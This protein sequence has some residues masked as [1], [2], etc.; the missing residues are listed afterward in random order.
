FIM[1]QTLSAIGLMVLIVAGPARAQDGPRAIIAKA[2]QAHG[3]S[4][5]LGQLRADRVKI[6]GTLLLGGKSVPF[7]S[8][9]LVQLPD[10]LKST[11]SLTTG[12]KIHTVVQIINGEQA[13]VTEDGQPQQPI[14]PAALSEM[15]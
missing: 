14:N 3:G 8:E 1:R 2:V 4:E 7:A 11:I 10:R 5:R 12:E 13:W 9:T 15:R 6:K